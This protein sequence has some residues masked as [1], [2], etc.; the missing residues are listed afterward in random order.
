MLDCLHRLQWGPLD[1]QQSR[2]RAHAACFCGFVAPLHADRRECLALM[3]GAN[4]HVRWSG[5]NVD[6]PFQD[7]DQPLLDAQSGCDS[8][9]TSVGYIAAA[10]G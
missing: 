9:P 7:R 5:G 1:P 10:G 2:F 8:A 6:M 3:V 4:P